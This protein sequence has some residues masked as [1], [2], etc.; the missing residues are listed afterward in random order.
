MKLKVLVFSCMVNSKF[1]SLSSTQD[2]YTP[3]HWACQQGEVKIVK[4]LLDNVPKETVEQLLEN[5]A[6]HATAKVC[7]C[8]TDAC[9]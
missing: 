4:C 1:L 7:A 8:V 2:A 3:L 6:R 9:H 5:G